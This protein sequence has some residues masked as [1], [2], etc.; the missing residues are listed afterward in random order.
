MQHPNIDV[1]S[2]VANI[3]WS[4]P[5]THLDSPLNC[6]VA[7]YNKTDL[8]PVDTETTASESYVVTD[9]EVLNCV[10][11]G[12]CFVTLTIKSRDYTGPSLQYRHS[13]TTGQYHAHA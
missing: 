5:W 1:A 8:S 13:E 6:S 7:L 10:A 2:G 9:Q 3:S 11:C 4:Y 12:G